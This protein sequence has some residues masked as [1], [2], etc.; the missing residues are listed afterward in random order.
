MPVGLSPVSTWAATAPL[1]GVS[2]QGEALPTAAPAAAGLVSP[3]RGKNV[4]EAKGGI[5]AAQGGSVTLHDPSTAHHTLSML[6]NA[7]GA[8]EPLNVTLPDV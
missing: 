4:P 7:L 3:L 6:E 2:P 8:L 5:A 1:A